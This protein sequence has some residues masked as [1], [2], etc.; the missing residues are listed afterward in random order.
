MSLNWSQLFARAERMRDEVLHEAW[1]K[2]L[3]LLLQPST[4]P[5]SLL[6]L[7]L[8]FMWPF[9][10]ILDEKNLLRGGT[11]FRLDERLIPADLMPPSERIE[12][13]PVAPAFWSRLEE[14]QLTLCTSG[15]TGEPKRIQ[16]TG[17]GLLAEVRDLAG[18]YG[19]R[20][21]DA[22][23]SLVSPLHIYGLLHSFLLPWFCRA[24]VEFVNFQKGPID[25]PDLAS[26][27]YAAVIAVPATWSFVKDLLNSRSLGTLVMSGAPFG[28]K[29]RGELQEFSR[30]PERA[31]E[32]LGST[33]T[34]GIGMRSLLEP[35]DCFRCLPSVRI[36]EESG[37]QWV[38][39]P[40][41]QPATRW[42]LAD[43]LEVKSDGRFLHQGRSDRIFKYAGQR[44][45]LAEVETA[46]SR[47]HAHAETLAFFHRDDAVAQGGWLE[48]WI[49]SDPLPVD[50]EVRRRYQA[51]TPAPFP[52]RV[53]FMPSFPRDGQGKVQILT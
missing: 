36:M 47:I 49:E 53:H 37:E 20:E 13:D 16:K 40:Y 24:S 52:H 9:G 2:E 39:S 31:V 4:R 7:A 21:G 42:V 26:T 44:Y 51:E 48:A 35:E 50:A 27:R 6:L 45:A 41:V 17:A 30:K 25:I 32:I 34:G 22:I 38:L 11:A 1:A 43:R 14:W 19:W 33:E 5:G 29:R 8:G 12:A 46:L 15:S 3:P 23:L 28:A 18:I 10:V